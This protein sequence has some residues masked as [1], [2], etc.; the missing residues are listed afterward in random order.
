MT[1]SDFCFQHPKSSNGC[2]EAT[3]DIHSVR[4]PGYM[5]SQEVLF[6]STGQILSIRHDSVDRKCYMPGILMAVRYVMDNNKFIYGLD[7]IL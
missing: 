1:E 4:M 5:A 7:N 6:G 3:S 2:R